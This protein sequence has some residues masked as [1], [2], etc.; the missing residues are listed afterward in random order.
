MMFRVSSF[1]AFS[2]CFLFFLFL[3]S[4]PFNVSAQSDSEKMLQ[5]FMESR[6]QMIKK[7]MDS[8]GNDDFFN[9]DMDDDFFNSMIGDRKAL[10]GSRFGGSLVSIKQVK[11]DDG[12]I[13]VF[14]KPKDKSVQLDI[15]TKEQM[16]VVKGKQMEKIENENNGNISRSMSQSS[17]SNSVSIP[18]GYKA[19]SPEAVD[20][21]IKIVLSPEKISPSGK[22]PIGKRAHED[23]L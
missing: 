2:T 17:F 18:F 5:D 20:D 4:F 12:T 6:R 16:I 7:M 14:I 21:Q 13:D 9:D 11:N 1:N 19:S 3:V 8:F 22:V 15:Q 23:T 10:F